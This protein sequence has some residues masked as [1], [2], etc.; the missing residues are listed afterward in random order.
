MTVFVL[1][2]RKSK[3]GSHLDT[4]WKFKVSIDGQFGENKSGKLDQIKEVLD[5]TIDKL[6]AIMNE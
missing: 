3:M 2:R 5:E 6:E 4:D 1:S